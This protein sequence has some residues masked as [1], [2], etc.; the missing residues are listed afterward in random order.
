MIETPILGRIRQRGVLFPDELAWCD[1]LKED[2][3]S[4]EQISRIKIGFKD[5]Q[6][7]ST[8]KLF[9]KKELCYENMTR[10]ISAFRSS[11]PCGWEEKNKTI[12]HF[13]T[14]DFHYMQLVQAFNACGEGVNHEFVKFYA[15]PERTPL[16]MAE[17]RK[18]AKK[19]RTIE[20]FKARLALF[21]LEQ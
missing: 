4:D 3:F 7:Y 18:F 10:I 12:E 2:G 8:I 6:D 15:T 20:S 1:S 14:S 5:G 17:I 13:C 21:T 11:W 16:Q 19:Y 9:A